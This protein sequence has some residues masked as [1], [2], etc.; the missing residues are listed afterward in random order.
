MIAMLDSPNILCSLSNRSIVDR[1]LSSKLSHL[2]TSQSEF[3][4]HELVF[5]VADDSEGD[6]EL[7]IILYW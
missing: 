1:Y 4:L 6:G 7:E 3:L 5:D 2:F